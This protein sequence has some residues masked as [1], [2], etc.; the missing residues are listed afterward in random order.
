M[1]NLVVVNDIKAWPLETDAVRIIDAA[2][3]LTDP[4]YFDLKR[5]RVFNLCR[6]YRYQS[7]GYY[8]SLLAEARGHKPLPSVVTIQ[9]LKQPFILRAAGDD[10]DALMQKSLSSLKADHFTLSIYFGRNLAKRYTA[11]SERLFRLF[12]A[13]LLR[14]SFDREAASGIWT[15]RSVSPIAARDIPEDHRDFAQVKAQEY[16]NKQSPRM[17]ARRRYRYDLAILHDPNEPLPPSDERALKRFAKAAEKTGFAVDF[18]E[19]TDLGSI[20]EFDALFIRA[21]TSVNHYTYRFARKAAA[22]GMAVIDDPES[23]LRCTNKVFLSELLERNHI[24]TPKTV[25]IHRSTQKALDALGFPC[26]LKQPDSSFSQGVVRVSSQEEMQSELPKL[27]SQSDLVIAQEFLPTDFDWRI[28][29]LDGRAIFACKYY[30]AANH[31]QIIKHDA[32]GNGHED[33]RAETLATTLVPDPVMRTALRAARLIGDGLYGV[34][35]KQVG[36]KAYVIEVNDNP[37]IDAGV[38]DRVE[39]DGLYLTVA[40]SLMRRVERLREG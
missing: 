3:Y 34:D 28:G 10:L 12:P 27:L 40:A 11:L 36:N 25:S 20:A 14:A 24:P 31:W 4:Q 1:E 16:F 32:D 30:M 19:R 26:I 39:G 17:I 15:L 38:E 23:I 21:T 33:G 22:E 18:I 29:V 7:T 8:V 5:A 6:S 35:L 2:T 13:P 37:S 9:D